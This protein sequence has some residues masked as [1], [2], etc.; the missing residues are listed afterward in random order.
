[1]DWEET[2]DEQKLRVQQGFNEKRRHY[3]Y[4]RTGLKNFRAE[5]EI[6]LSMGNSPFRSVLEIRSGVRRMIEDIE[7]KNP[8][9]DR[10]GCHR[11]LTTGDR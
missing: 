5:M 4:W 10:Y 7:R 1:M 11:P 8:G 3:K 6:V 9:R 2:S